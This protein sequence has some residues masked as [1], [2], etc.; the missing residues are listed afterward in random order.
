[1][2]FLICVVAFGLAGVAVR[3]EDPPE[4]SIGLMLKLDE[5]KIVVVE[6]VKDSPADKAGFKAGDVLVKVGDHKVKNGAEEED[7]ATAVKEVV[8]NKPGTKIKLT[9][10]R[11]DKEKVIE[12]TVGKR[13]EIFPK[14]D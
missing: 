14:K 8:K 6:A 10:K 11:D 1:M 2:R 4:G 3:A 7:L 5:G 12:V 9:V 13:A